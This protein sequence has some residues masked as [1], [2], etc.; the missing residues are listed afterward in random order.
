MLIN[1]AGETQIT[2][3]PNSGKL[4]KN[5]SK[6]ARQPLRRAY[7]DAYTTA[8]GSQVLFEAF[9][10][11]LGYSMPGDAAFKYPLGPVKQKRSFCLVKP[12][13]ASLHHR[14]FL[15]CDCSTFICIQQLY[16]P[17]FKKKKFFFSLCDA[18]E[19]LTRRLSPTGL[20]ITIREEERKK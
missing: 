10:L 15:L 8:V 1:A 13:F 12:F 20:A 14:S 9:I 19:K 4:H 5:F 3:P 2:R 18:Q 11:H 6:G 16:S 17:W 7:I